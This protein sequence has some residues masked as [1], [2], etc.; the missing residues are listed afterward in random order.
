M[1]FLSRYAWYYP[2][3]IDNA[4]L[5]KTLNFFIGTHD[6]A[7]FRSSE[8]KREN[9][10]RTIDS[11]DLTYIKRFKVYKITIKGQKFLQHMIRRIVGASIAVASYNNK[12]SSSIVGF[13]LL[14]N[15]YIFKSHIETSFQL[16]YSL[17]FHFY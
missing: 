14:D 16:F 5:K 2:H 8:D 6:F 17:I 3:S 10:I 13:V 15:V 9:T 7:S 12:S 4:M 1:P 11:I